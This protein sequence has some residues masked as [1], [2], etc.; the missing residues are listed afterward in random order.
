MFLERRPPPHQYGIYST[1]FAIQLLA[2][3]SRRAERE[4]MTDVVQGAI[5]LTRQ[6]AAHNAALRDPAAQNKQ[7]HKRRELGH[8]DF[9]L[10][11]KHSLIL[12]AL[13]ALTTLRELHADY[14]QQLAESKETA[15]AIADDLANTGVD[16]RDEA[17]GTVATAWPWHR[18]GGPGLVDPIPTAYAYTAL[19]LPLLAGEALRKSPHQVER[20]L[21]AVLFDAKVRP[22]MKAI[23]VNRLHAAN[24]PPLP[25]ALREMVSAAISAEL[26]LDS[27]LPWQEVYHYD[28]FSTGGHL[29]HY[30]P[31]IWICPRL[32]LAQALLVLTTGNFSRSVLST[33][34]GVVSNIEH[35]GSFRVSSAKPPSLQACWR[36]E[37]FLRVAESFYA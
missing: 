7:A 27:P 2:R 28:V 15:T 14:N 34:H 5:F 30:K 31:W 9:D 37:E 33:L 1:S 19:N 23:V 18:V 32:E 35:Y 24:R 29:A 12:E 13:S 26:D 17:A 25:D 20:Y 22:V 36:A 3:T 8:T 6:F 21:T 10:V 4:I 11:L 16:S